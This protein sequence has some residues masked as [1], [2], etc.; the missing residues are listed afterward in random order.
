ML[1]KEIFRLGHD[2][3]LANAHK[4]SQWVIYRHKCKI[5]A[6]SLWVFLPWIRI[7]PEPGDLTLGMAGKGVEVEKSLRIDLF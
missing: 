5:M 4:K 3:N 6:F 1:K 2:R 7:S